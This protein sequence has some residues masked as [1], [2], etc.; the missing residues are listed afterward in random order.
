MHA[1]IVMACLMVL[2]LL[3]GC[4]GKGGGRAD[5][6]DEGLD[7]LGL[8]ATDD[9]GVIRGVVVDDAIKPLGGA[10][11]N[12]VGL[13]T[14]QAYNTTLASNQEG[15]FGA[16]GLEP[17]TYAM[18]VTKVG[19]T[20]V[21]RNV[22]VVAGDSD[23]PIQKVQLS[24]D[25]AQMPYVV[26]RQYEAY[27][28][29]SLTAPVVSFAACDEPG[30]KD[31]TNNQFLFDVEAEQL[32]TWV[33]AEAVWSSS[34][35]SGDSLSLSLTDFSQGPQVVVASSSGAS[36]IFIA[37]N[38]SV[39]R[40]FA[41]GINNTMTFRLFSTS[42]QGTDVVQEST[43][44][45]PYSGS[46]YPVVNSTG[47]PAAYQDNVIGND[48]T[49][50]AI[51]LL[52]NPFGNPQCLETAVLFNSCFGVGGAGAVVQQ[53]VSVYVHVFYGY[54][55]PEGWRFSDSSMVPQPE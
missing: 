53:Q 20:T 28:G 13:S 11:V 8:K 45:G 14:A 26:G 50:L 54:A 48:P 44:Q 46:V 10:S 31:I 52:N 55:P 29:C 21:R 41:Y 30:L 16:D 22:D 24:V 6:V 40:D 27:I 2:T 18:S 51:C 9:T 38:Q 15:L 47:I 35:P 43:F 36:P 19:F 34:Q 32:P 12:L 39:A 1:R 42:Q 49:C 3:A 4:T 37:I 17:G 33:Q 5:A 23:P 25:R 7:Q